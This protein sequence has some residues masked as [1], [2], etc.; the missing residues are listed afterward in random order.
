[1]FKNSFFSFEK[2]KII[3]NIT[4]NL[5]RMNMNKNFYVVLMG[6]YSVVLFS[7]SG[8]VIPL[9]DSATHSL[10]FNLVNQIWIRHT[11]LNPGS[12]LDGYP[13]EQVSDIGLRRTRMQVLGMINDYTF[14]YIQVGT[15]NLSFNGQRKQG[16]FF[17][18]AHAEL[19]IIG[20][21]LALGSGLT[22]WS[23]LSRYASPAAGSIL[24]L[25]APIYQQ[26][27]NDI[28][29]QFLR[30]FSIYSKGK[31]G[32]L[33]YRLALSKPMT[34]GFNIPLAER[35][36]FSP[37]PSK[38]QTQGYF[39]FQ[40]KEKEANLIPYLPGSYLGK[41]E[42]LNIG[43]GWIF[44]QMATWQ[45]E[46]ISGDTLLHDMHLLGIDIFWDKPLNKEKLTALTFYS[47]YSY[48][49]FG[50]EYIR[51]LGVMNPA[52]GN[53]PYTSFGSAFPIT[54]TGNTIY[55]QSAYLM[56]KDLLGK[57]GTLQPFYSTQI[58]SYKGLNRAMTMMEGG[59]NWLI[60]GHK[61]KLS[62]MVQNRPVF[63]PGGN[64]SGRKNMWV[65]QF[66]I[67]I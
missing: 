60:D 41:K 58:S 16:I 61:S 27:T 42:V 56:K 43:G 7:Q 4:L 2:I 64:F 6:F 3:T 53:T 63:S 48:T 45:L 31:I 50:P 67:A 28:N 5:M 54:G 66:Q 36:T 55:F 14:I 22:G 9:N 12:T 44:Q 52:N 26:A 37:L 57:M 51:F 8:L 23:G 24:G 38:L 46:A 65:T 47:A 18:D 25:D 34:L 29:D 19:K 33:D 30:K 11:D 39:M 17:H 15:N 21:R 20:D 1:V 32:I 40:L 62:G 35:T 13:I 59:I 49:D 10:K